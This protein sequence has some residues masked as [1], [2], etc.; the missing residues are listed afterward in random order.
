MSYITWITA[1]G[2]LGTVPENKFYEKGIEA[3]DSGGA[4][5]YYRFLSGELPP[6]LQVL[7]D[8]S[9]QGLPEIP[10]TGGAD[11]NYT[12]RFTVRAS[13]AAGAVA[14]RS[15]SITVASL[16]PPV[17]VNEA[18]KIASIFDGTYYE[19][20][21]EAT[22]TANSVLTFSVANGVIPPGLTL[23]PD[24]TL[25]GFP[26]LLAI[27]S[28]PELTGF[29]ASRHDRYGYDFKT[30]TTSTT[31]TY[32]FG[33]RVTDGLYADVRQYKLQVLS[34]I[35]YTADT[36]LITADDT[37]LKVSYDNNYKPVLTVPAGDIGTIR[38]GDNFNFQFTAF[39][40]MGDAVGFALTTSQLVAFDQ[41]GSD[42]VDEL[43]DPLPGPGVSGSGFDTTD[44]D[45]S[46]QELAHGLSL[47]EKSGWLTGTA[48]SQVEPT[49]TYT[50]KVTPYNIDKPGVFGESKSYYLTVLGSEYN[51]IGWI[52][53]TD[54]GYI[55]EGKPCT[56]Q[57]EAA[58]LKGQGIEYSFEGGALEE[59]PQ[60]IKLTT[61]GLLIGR[62]SFRRFSVD[63]DTTII[64]VQDTTGI[65][66]GMDVT[67]PGVGSGAKVKAITG[68]NTLTV[69]PAVISAAGSAL[70]FSDA[71]NSIVAITTLPNQTTTITDGGLT[72]FDNVRDFTVRATTADRKSSGVKTF[73]LRLTGYSL[74]PYENV[75]LKALPNLTQRNYFYTI[76]NDESVFPEDLIYRPADPWYGK[77]KDIRM[78]L[79]PGVAPSRLSQY[80]AAIVH[81]HYDKNIRFGAIK[82]ARAVDEF[83]NTK[84]EVVYVEMIDNKTD[85][86]RTV[87]EEQVDLSAFVNNYF[88]DSSAYRYLYPNSFNHM[89]NKIGGTLG[90]SN[91]GALPDWMTSPQTDGRVLGFVPAMVLAYTKP[92]GANTIK[93][94]LETSGYQLNNI[95]FTADRYQLD[96]SL[97]QY[98]DTDNNR[99][100]ASTE[101]TFDV[102]AGVGHTVAAVNYA[103]HVA[104]DKINNRTIDYINNNGGLDGAYNFKDGET[105]VF[106]KQENIENPK[107]RYD[108][109]VD[110]NDFYAEQGFSSEGLD[111]YTIIPG[112]L[113]KQMKLSDVD[114]RGGVWKINLDPVKRLIQLEFVQEILVSQRVR[115][116]SGA[117]H[118]NTVIMRNPVV[119]PGETVPGWVSATKPEMLS[120][121]RTTFD[122]NGTK[123]LN[124][125]DVYSDPESGDKYVKFPQR[126]VFV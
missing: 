99:Y 113:E 10:A 11:S 126:G 84:Y 102:V 69:G 105:L 111:T 70:T 48:P 81:N 117:S 1:G 122:G 123:F 77:T 88:N 98:Y 44:F 27:Q 71:D 31:Q 64:T 109:W 76:I 61:N 34:K 56:V 82:T 29:D 78:L 104:F 35:G 124:F 73:K 20:K 115:V 40:P 62:P 9:I 39:E 94:R 53:D 125:R 103:V 93:Y 51:E 28:S 42:G 43:G 36:N 96:N 21:F 38:E 12:F 8:G 106:F 49:K 19:Y 15:F 58:D 90:F 74:S 5:V 68:P 45:Q 67:G 116:A 112:Y 24:G 121:K 52:T 114:Q 25:S 118:S 50:F 18:G 91:R 119:Q 46:L 4:Q 16:N 26:D 59:L 57:I 80:Q 33:I 95:A 110:Y 17:L 41:D 66:V 107:R 47:H 7:I 89:S 14:D 6:G 55:D 85:Q 100:I 54:L 32:S 108:G 13:T 30:L 87:R 37:Y 120:G 79:L 72:T 83:F 63:A 60:G 65:A 23:N 2:N 22:D 92:G 75:Y 101:T 97:S 86:G 3:T